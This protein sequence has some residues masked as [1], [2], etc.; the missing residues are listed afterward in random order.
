MSEVPLGAFR[1][2]TSKANV[3]GVRPV[4]VGSAR[5]YGFMTVH[6]ATWLGNGHEIG[7]PRGTRRFCIE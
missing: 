3:L 2:S 4:Q 6:A 5:P 7:R 1:S